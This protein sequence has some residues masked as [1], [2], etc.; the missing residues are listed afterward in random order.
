M[1]VVIFEDSHWHAFAPLSLSRPVF[2]LA[3]GMC[4]LLEKQIRHLNP[5]RLTLWVRPEFEAF[6]RE[7]IAPQTGVPTDVNAPLD[8]APAILINGRTALSS[9]LAAPSREAI[10]AVNGV[11]LAAMTSRAGLTPGDALSESGRWLDLLKLN[12]TECHGRLLESPVDLIYW[13]E[14]SLIEDFAGLKEPS[15]A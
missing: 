9:R 13:N 12:E 3:S 11:V 10:H 6:C 2:S 14:Q 7:R 8:G 4:T 1:H 15:Q 5:S